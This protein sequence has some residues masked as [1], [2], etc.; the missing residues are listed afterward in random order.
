M[1]NKNQNSPVNRKLIAGLLGILLGSFGIHK[2]YLGQTGWGIVYLI[3]FWTFIPGLVGIVE[4]IIY[5][6]MKEADFNQK[7]PAR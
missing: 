1:E 6:T 5:L 3:F 2:F 7:Y 4:G